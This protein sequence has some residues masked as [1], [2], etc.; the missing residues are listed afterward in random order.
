MFK[1][2]KLK[3]IYQNNKIKAKRF[4]KNLLSG[5]YFLR[6]DGSLFIFL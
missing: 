3:V 6:A 2:L 4:N 1:G 5:K